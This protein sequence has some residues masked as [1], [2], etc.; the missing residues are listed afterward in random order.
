MG[1]AK[2]IEQ[3]RQAG[4]LNIVWGAG[5]SYAGPH[6][7]KALLQSL[8]VNCRLKIDGPE[9]VHDALMTLDPQTR[10]EKTG[11]W[12]SNWAHLSL[13]ELFRT[14]RAARV[15]TANFDG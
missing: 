8:R 15:L 12:A 13:A 3:L 9:G 11:R 7:A 6:A 14:G 4:P 2:T 1:I 10:R 5:C